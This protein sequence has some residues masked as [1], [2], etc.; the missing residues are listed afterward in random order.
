MRIR[1]VEAIPI[2]TT[3]KETFRYGTTERKDCANVI[4]RLVTDDGLVGYGEAT[5]QAAFTTETQAS[6]VEAIEQVAARSLVGRDAVDPVVL[7]TGLARQLPRAPFTLTAVDLALWDLLGKASGMPVAALLGGRYRDRVPVHGSV[8]WGPAEDMVRVAQQQIEAGFTTLKLYAGRGALDA[9]LERLRAVR[10]VVP[11]TVAFMLDI[12]G[13][14]TMHDCERAFPT[15]KELGVVVLEQPIS[16][17]D[18]G[19]QARVTA[20]APMVVAADEAVYSPEDVFAIARDRRAHAVNL[21][22]S[23]LGGLQRAHQCALVAE[24]SMTT[25]LIGSVLELGIATAAGLHLAASIEKLPFP[26]YLIGPIKYRQDV[27]SPSLQVD[28][29]CVRLP[30]GPGLGIDVD[31]ELLAALDVRNA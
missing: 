13:Q 24:A 8:G 3:F 19:G 21:G 5:P 25:V 14:W 9:D 22:L 2:Q 12:N 26:S 16:A 11:D 29:G 7:I 10:N 4:V 30:Q 23:K 18:L 27:A 17:A 6:I 1:S 15:L 20:L 28:N 31:D